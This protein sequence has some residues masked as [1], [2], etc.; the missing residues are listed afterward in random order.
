VAI[1]VAVVGFVQR[2]GVRVGLL[3]G[4]AL[5]QTGE[6]S[7]VLAE[8]AAP[9]GLLDASLRQTFVAGSILTLLATPFL[10]RAAPHLANLLTRL[11]EQVDR[12]RG[13]EAATELADHVVIVGFGRAGQTL[14][15]VLE[16]SR[17]PYCIV[18]QNPQT[19]AE[20]RKRGEVATYGDATRASILDRMNVRRARL[21]AVVTNDAAATERCIATVH[22]VAPQAVI[23]ARAHYVKEIDGLIAAGASE[24]VAEEFEAAIDVF[25]KVL[26]RFGI[27]QPSIA[28]FAEAMRMEGYEFLRESA[29]LPIDPWVAEVLAEVTQEWVDVPA[30]DWGERTIVELAVRTRTGANV[31]A[32]RRDAERISNPPPGFAIRPGDALLVM[33]TSEELAKLR[34]LLDGIG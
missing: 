14:A 18:D 5:A 6:F 10:M 31:L 33:A 22:R 23:V 9:A 1:I 34:E 30:G 12:L 29:T 28:Q 21:V 32:V 4:L 3:T 7:F 16:A 24:V 11:L 2:R 13:V 19:V 27:A 17:I 20:A 8:A 26:H 25:S 15:R